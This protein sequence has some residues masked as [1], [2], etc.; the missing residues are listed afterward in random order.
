[1]TSAEPAGPPRRACKPDQITDVRIRQTARLDS[2]AFDF[3]T[4]SHA[5]V[6]DLFGQRMAGPVSLPGWRVWDLPSRHRC[7]R[8]RDP[9]ADGSGLNRHGSSCDD[10]G[11]RSI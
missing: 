8:P 9:G 4:H 7:V 3:A 1:M 2:T 11:G 6:M 10:S 5:Y